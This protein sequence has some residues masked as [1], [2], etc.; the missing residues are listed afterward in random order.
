MNRLDSLSASFLLVYL[1][2]LGIGASVAILTYF[3]TTSDNAEIQFLPPFSRDQGFILLAALGG[4]AGSFLHTAQS[5]I[6]YI[7]NAT[8]RASWSAWYGLRP[9]IGAVL[10]LAIYFAFRAGLVAGASVVNPYGVVAIGLLGGWFSKTTTDKLQ[11]VFETLFKTDEDRNRKDKLRTLERPVID[12]V[13]PSPVPQG[14]RDVIIV[15][16]NFLEGAK[17]LVDGDEVD[18]EFVSDNVLQATVGQRSPAGT[19]VVIKVQNPRGLEA[20]SK[21]F[22][23]SFA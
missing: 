16:R 6:S 12:F 11:E 20:V 5:L 3:P 9:W 22:E 17:A 8:F 7:G 2:I 4:I 1:L 19:S 10:G 14:T 15:G 13:K 23:I 21:G 18:A